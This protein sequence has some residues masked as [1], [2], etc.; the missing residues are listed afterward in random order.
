[1]EKDKPKKGQPVNAVEQAPAQGAAASS[2]QATT[3]ALISMIEM[4]EW[5]LKIN[6]D[7][8]VMQV[9]VDR[10]SDGGQRSSGSRMSARV[11]A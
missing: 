9:G 7:D 5:I 4:E 6:A 10:T 3:P 11:R 2:T 8:H 1:M